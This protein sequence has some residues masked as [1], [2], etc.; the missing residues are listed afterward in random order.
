MK[1]A[2]FN[3]VTM[4]FVT[5]SIVFST[6]SCVQGEYEISE[7]NL[8]LE[9]TVFQEG[10]SI[11]LGSTEAIKVSD[12]L[13]EL[14]PEIKEQLTITDGVY[15]LS[16]SETFDFSEDLSFLSESFSV[17]GFYI[18]DKFPFEIWE[19]T[20]G[21]V[22]DPLYPAVNVFYRSVIPESD[23]DLGGSVDMLSLPEELVY[24]GDMLF[25]DAVLDFSMK[26]I[27]L[28][29][30]SQ[31]A[32]VTLDLDIALPEMIMLEN[33][34]NGGV[35]KRTGTL[36][37]DVIKI[38]P[39]RILGLNVN[40]DIAKMSE[41]L[42]DVRISY[43]G[44]VLI[45]DKT[46]DIG[47]VDY[48]ELDVDTRLMTAGSEDS[49]D[50]SKVTGKVDYSIEPVSVDMDLSSF[51]NS[52]ETEEFKATLDF[53]RFSLALEVNTNLSIPLVADLAVVPY[54]DDAPVEGKKLEEAIMIRR[55]EASAEPSMIRFWISN[56][57]KGKDPYTPEG[58]EHVSMDIL[59]LLK[60][61]P[62]R[63]QITLTADTDP[64]SDCSIMASDYGHVLEGTYTFC[65]PLEF[66]KDMLLEF[67]TV[68]PDL[69]EVLGRILQYGSLALTGD[70]ESSLP[71]GLEMRYNFLDSN[72]NRIDMV[73]DAGKQI[74]QSGTID[75]DAVKTDVNILVD[76]KKSADLSD[77]NALELSFR[78]TNVPGA[79]LKE[80]SFI[81]AKLQV[82]VPEGVT[83][84]L[85]D[86]ISEEE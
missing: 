50:I 10:V 34:Q 78:T 81:K 11:P 42:K 37:G 51:T 84:D 26:V 79:P 41:F 16:T 48:L 72:G 59:S 2:L 64:D 66:G 36:E 74:V 40:K 49:I 6:L 30:L 80:D 68:I 77:I 82:L 38:D 58:Y 24:V 15:A 27:G 44:K 17:K 76:I 1:S 54:K 32:E 70:I 43:G 25:K 14:D 4:L 33:S 53:N 85:K 29:R 62:D 57:P 8:N 31:N 73:E 21:D 69:P 35:I 46:S 45:E 22:S 75:G 71:F 12:L 52:L 55:P 86:F 7:E 61:N 39:I 20:S 83:L 63:L 19:E 13:D 60:E 5:A 47:S 3:R 18:S 9:V 65:L 23:I 28:D 56:F 67:S